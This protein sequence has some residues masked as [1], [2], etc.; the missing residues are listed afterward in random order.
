MD[1]FQESSPRKFLSFCLKNPTEESHQ[2]PYPTFVQIPTEISSMNPESQ[3]QFDQRISSKKDG[4][5]EDVNA[6]ADNIVRLKEGSTVSGTEHTVDS[7]AQTKRI[8]ALATEG[9]GEESQI[10]TTTPVPI[11]QGETLSTS[12]SFLESALRV[13]T[14]AESSLP[15]LVTV[16]VPLS[17]ERSETQQLPYMKFQ[18]CPD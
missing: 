4:S 8:P 13:T 7:D 5:D 15:D 2:T 17:M 10:R 9:S 3:N 12:L 6:Y 11:S 14:T 18:R 1:S 16:T